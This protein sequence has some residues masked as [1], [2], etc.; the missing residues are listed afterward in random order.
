[1][2]KIFQMRFVIV[3]SAVITLSLASCLKDLAPPALSTDPAKPALSHKTS[4]SEHHEYEPNEL[5]VKFKAGLSESKRDSII[6][7]INGEI[8]ER[9]DTKSMERE[10]DNEGLLLIHTSLNVQDAINKLKGTE[11]EYAEPNYIYTYGA[12]AS[13]PIF[14]ANYPLWGMNAINSFGSQA[15]IAWNAGH[16]GSASVFVGVIDEGIQF[17]HPNLTGQIWTNPYDPVDGIDNDGNGYIDDIHGWDFANND[18]TIYDGGNNGKVDSHGTHVSGI[19]GAA[20]N[21]MGVVGINWNIT[22]ISAKFIGSNGGNTAD[23]VKAID[24]ITDL[25]VRHGLNIIATNNSWSG[26]GFSQ[27]L[28]NA[29]SRA[30]AQGILFVAAAGNAD[31]NN[32]I[33]PSYPSNYNLP[34]IIAVAAIADD[35]SLAPFSNWG[36]TTV[37]LGAPGVNIWSTIAYNS[38]ASYSGTSMATPFVTGAAALYL[39]THPGA[40]AAIIKS[41]ILKSTTPTIT[42]KNKTI[43]GGRLN[44][45]GF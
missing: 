14:T 7:L 38:Y 20:N 3:I 19:I 32:D 1:M 2:S 18:N 28:Y 27:A 10:G 15:S 22:I 13:A 23:A 34:N 45:S 9:I 17:D 42:L 25:K 37:D 4:L 31:N 6:S 11:I 40:S 16:T 35:G 33:T 43:S 41:E 26:G 36:A 24:Y 5:L 29:I 39:S 44:V 30:D 8:S 12:T 21:N